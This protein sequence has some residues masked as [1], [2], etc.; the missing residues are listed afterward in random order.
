MIEINLLHVVHILRVFF[1]E[2]KK[3]FL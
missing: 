1:Y 2:R 3:N